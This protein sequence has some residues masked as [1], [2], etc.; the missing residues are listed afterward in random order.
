MK[1]IKERAE[2]YARM[3]ETDCP[4]IV[5][6]DYETGATEERMLLTEWHKEDPTERGD[7]LCKV[8]HIDSSGKLLYTDY[9]VLEYNNG[10][11]D[12][13]VGEELI[14]WRKIYDEEYD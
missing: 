9:Q 7:Y 1:T 4:K 14:G 12:I 13:F 3:V 2:D 6:H 5:A 10:W 11:Y 8:A